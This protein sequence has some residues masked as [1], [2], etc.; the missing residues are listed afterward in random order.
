MPSHGIREQRALRSRRTRHDDPLM[1]EES[2]EDLSRLA[3]AADR[4]G[5]GEDAIAVERIALR[6]YYLTGDAAAIAASHD[7][8]GNYLARNAADYQQALAHHLAAALLCSLDGRSEYARHSLVSVARDLSAIP[9]DAAVPASVGELSAAVGDAP[10]VHLDRLLA[11]ENDSPAAIEETLA[12][13]LRRARSWADPDTPLPRHFAVWDPVIAGLIAA[14]DGDA[15]ARAAVEEHLAGLAGSAD[16]ARLAGVMSAI[17][18]G[19]R[20]LPDDLG[21]IDTAIAR[22]ALA[23]LDGDSRDPP[24]QLWPAIVFTG[25]ISN[26][27]TAASGD[28]ATADQLRGQFSRAADDS[29]LGPLTDALRR[30]LDGDR[31]PALARGLDSVSAAVVLTILFH[32]PPAT[33]P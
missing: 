3:D 8:F 22:R 18:H 33:Q 16:W 28:A 9:A 7:R 21:K 32:V 15:E 25:L 26:V 31:S 6:L 13:L 2:G 17:L 12:G 14:R 29:E 11:E 27:V 20:S 23:A 5:H 1:P 10:G 19:Q 4:A 24:A 30:I